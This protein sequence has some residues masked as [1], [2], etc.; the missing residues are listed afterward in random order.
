M[1]TDINNHL[2]CVLESHK[3]KKEQVL[4]DKHISKRNEIKEALEEKYGANIYTPFNSGSYAKN[5][6]V[7]T[8]F[9]FDFMV[10]FKRDAFDTLENMFIDIFDF[11]DDKYRTSAIVKK[12]KVSIGLEFFPDEI[13]DVIKGTKKRPIFYR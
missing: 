4:L 6:A 5:T 1:S 7:N 11:L 10:P 12:Q 3:I 2:N 13:G 9:D 8:K